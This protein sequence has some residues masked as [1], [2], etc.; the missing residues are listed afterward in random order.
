MR[1]DAVRGHLFLMWPETSRT[2]FQLFY[3]KEVEGTKYLVRDFSISCDTDEY[4][5]YL[6]WGIV[7]V[8]MYP[9]GVPLAYLCILL[10]HYDDL[11]P[12]EAW[13]PT[14]TSLTV[15]I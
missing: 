9:V 8:I 4:V 6:A 13:T 7:A 2:I 11:Y 12:D 1:M 10:Y 5:F 14:L 15:T 3:C